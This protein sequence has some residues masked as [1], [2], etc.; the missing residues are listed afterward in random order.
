[1]VNLEEVV[2]IVAEV[3]SMDAITE[4][5]QFP[6]HARKIVNRRVHARGPEVSGGM[7][8][9]EEDNTFKSS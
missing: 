6:E 3:D 9:P 2:G 1:M 8:Q 5:R 4:L 7:R